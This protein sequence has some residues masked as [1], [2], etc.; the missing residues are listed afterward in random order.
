MTDTAVTPTL[1]TFAD[2][3]ARLAVTLPGYE[4]RVEQGRLAHAVEA[5]IE[6]G[7]TK[8]RTHLIAEAGCGTGKSLGY[9]IPAILSG[10]R[11]IVSTATKA[12]Q[13]QIAGKDLPFLA[14]NLGVA[15]RFAILKGRANYLCRAK[16]AEVDPAEVTTGNAIRAFIENAPEGF[17]GTRE[18]FPFEI[19][20]AEWARIASDSEDCKDEG[21][22]KE[23][24]IIC[25]AEIARR[26]ALAANVVVV[27]HALYL[28]DLAVKVMS[29]G[30]AT[31]LGP[32]STV[33]FDEAHEVEEYAS[34]ALGATFKEVGI[35]ALV[36]EVSNFV[37]RFL[38]DNPAASTIEDAGNAVLMHLA[39]LWAVLEPGRVRK[40]N[41]FEHADEF[42]NLTNALNDLAGSLISSYILDEVPSVDLE[43]A[44][45]AKKRVERRAMSAATRFERIVTESFEDLVRWVEVETVRG[46]ERKVLK[47]APV[48]VGPYLSRHL[49]DTGDCPSCE[50]TGS[51]EEGRDC[52]GCGGTGDAPQVTAILTSATMS[53]AGTMTYI[54]GRLGITNH[55]DLDVGSPFDF[56]RQARLYVPKHLPA[57]TPDN[58]AAWS[59]MMIMEIERLVRASDGR[60]LLL[61]TSSAQMRS[62][63]EV[64][65]GRLPYTCLMQG[66][67]PNKEL[68]ARF[69][70]DIH[71]VLFATRSF[72]TGVDFQGEACS[73]V[74]IDKLPFPVPTE[75]LVEA[76]C[77]AIKAAGGSDFRDY[78]IPV[79]SLVLKQAFGR[80]I[81]HRNDSGTVAILDSRLLTKGYGKTIL[82]SL[83]PAGRITTPDEVESFY[84]GAAA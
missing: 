45:K 34:S 53:V 21:C 30:N 17:G 13:D 73:L 7:S 18:E 46:N 31:F 43:K 62:A 5:A 26:E 42:V 59:S 6:M 63:F 14:D 27:N 67:A 3:E 8:P 70:S 69:A 79:M 44:K 10:K 12:L 66:Q 2:A 68:A 77:D 28:T 4:S 54:A 83:P 49:F 15:F 23:R 9:L 37:R 52:K 29:D 51:S 41:L 22:A 80:L 56:R 20:A 84:A 32:H 81:R 76:R 24:P 1:R 82:N 64:L 40:A 71:S 58:R 74:V 78:T 75:P 50:G 48:H 72:M 19:P 57:P 65:A 55:V 35:R 11:V 25:Y 38:A 47:T 39:S 36:A 60:A 61:F 33:I 16:L